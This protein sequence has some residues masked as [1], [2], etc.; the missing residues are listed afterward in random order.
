MRKEDEGGSLSSVA[1]ALGYSQTGPSTMGFLKRLEMADTDDPH[2]HS[3]PLDGLSGRDTS[4]AVK[5]KFKGLIRQLPAKT[6]LDKL[7]DMFLTKFNW[8]YYA[9]DPDIL[10]A[11]LD[12][13]NRIPFKQLSSM[14]PQALPP[15]LRAFPAVLFQIIATSLLIVD[16]GP[17][18]EF[19]ALKY[20]GSMTFEDLAMDYSD[21]GVAIVNLFDKRSLTLTTVQASFLRA[22][23]L[24]FM[25]KV[26]ESVSPG[27][28]HCVNCD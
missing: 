2:A 7:I 4:Q 21:S 15:E 10:R 22:S 11:Q 1:A 27:V 13:W 18:S 24:K 6:Y 23:F 14:G 20:A 16:E 19:E 8:Q 9:V 5:D 17:D 12:Q 28:F 26:T 25:A 3:Y